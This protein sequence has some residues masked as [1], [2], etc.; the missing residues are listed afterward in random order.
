MNSENSA[1]VNPPLHRFH[2]QEIR[3][4]GCF[5]GEEIPVIHSDI[6]LGDALALVVAAPGE[7]GFRGGGLEAGDGALFILDAADFDALGEVVALD[8]HPEEVRIVRVVPEG[9]LKIVLIGIVEYLVG[10]REVDDL[11]SEAVAFVHLQV[12]AGNGGCDGHT[13]LE[14]V[15][16]GSVANGVPE[17]DSPLE[18]RQGCRPRGVGVHDGNLL[19]GRGDIGGVVAAEAEQHHQGC[20]RAQGHSRYETAHAAKVGSERA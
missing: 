14:V 16:Q 17:M 13:E 2:V 7:E 6:D 4:A 20:H 10:L 1:P 12:V 11:G 18:C 9:D 15:D 3:L 8:V 19:C 5:D